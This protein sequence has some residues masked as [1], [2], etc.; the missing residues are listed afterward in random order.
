MS[1]VLAIY[2]ALLEAG[3]PEAPARRIVE[4]LER[5]M[6]TVLATKVD[7]FAVKE[8][9]A[10]V[11]QEIGTVRQEIVEL[12][13]QFTLLDHKIDAAEGRMLLRME[14]LESR[15]ESRLFVKLG[16]LMLGLFSISGTLFAL[17]R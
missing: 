4:A 5:D 2:D 10:S 8:D 11:R 3:I 16:G 1:A 6:T 14:N 9:V 17:Y 15:L 7:L 12:R 13:G